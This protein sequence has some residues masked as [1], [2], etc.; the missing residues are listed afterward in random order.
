MGRFWRLQD[1]KLI[2]EAKFEDVLEK[3]FFTDT[4]VMVQFMAN[5][6]LKMENRSAIQLGEELLTTE[7]FWRGEKFEESIWITTNYL[8]PASAM[9]KFA[10]KR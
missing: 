8:I 5:E 10:D 3:R 2:F 9:L 1:N 7:N 6:S 4:I